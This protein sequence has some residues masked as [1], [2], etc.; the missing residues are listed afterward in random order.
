MLCDTG[1]SKIYVH[2][3]F[4]SKADYTGKVSIASLANSTKQEAP[5]A[6]VHLNV[7]GETF[8]NVKVAVMNTH[9]SVLIGNE[10]ESIGGTALVVTR[11][12]AKE[13][14]KDED[15]AKSEQNITKVVPYPI[16]D[17]KRISNDRKSSVSHHVKNKDD[18]IKKDDSDSHVE[19]GKRK[20]QNVE[21]LEITEPR[22][23]IGLDKNETNY[24]QSI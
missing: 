14:Q 22:F 2:P 17:I 8:E 3:D 18:E 4:V 5:L 13:I 10:L 24:A 15:R 19:Q 12:R 16:D 21:E 11:S 6:L 9:F 1:A 7:D 23:D 20:D